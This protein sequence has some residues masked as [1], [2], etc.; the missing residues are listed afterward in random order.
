MEP[1]SPS[2]PLSVGRAHDSTPVPNAPWTLSRPPSRVRRFVAGAVTALRAPP[3]RSRRW[4]FYGRDCRPHY[5][6][7][8][9]ARDYVAR[10]V[11]WHAILASAGSSSL[12]GNPTP[13]RGGSR[14]TEPIS[15][16]LHPGPGGF[17]DGSGWQAVYDTLT[18][19]GIDVSVVQNPTVSLVGDVAADPVVLDAQA[20]RVILV[21]HSFGGV[22]ITEGRRPTPRWRALVYIAAF[23]PDTGE[24]VDTLITTRR[25]APP[26]RRSCRRSTGSCSS[27]TGEVP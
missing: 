19:R 1:H 6:A 23:A 4:C 18:G 12:F 13:T 16:R 3:H 22:V 5:V 25:P 20:R 9:Y 24:S 17:V 7:T 26:F 15:E 14:S 10:P 27:M 21:G 11:T 2:R 8:P